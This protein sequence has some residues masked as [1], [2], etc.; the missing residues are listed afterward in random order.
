MKKTL[1]GLLIVL[2]AIGLAACKGGNEPP[3]DTGSTTGGDTPVAQKTIKNAPDAVGDIVLK[4]GR[5]IA[6]YDGLTLT[7]EEKASAIAV[8]FYAGGDNDLG[9]R[10]LGV[11]LFEY[12]GTRSCYATNQN[13]MGGKTN[14]ANDEINGL[15]NQNIIEADEDDYKTQY[16]SSSDFDSDHLDNLKYPAF[17][18]ADNYYDWE[19]VDIDYEYSNPAALCHDWYVPA[20]KELTALLNKHAIINKAFDKISN[21]ADKFGNKAYWSST[22][23]NVHYGTTTTEY[24][25]YNAWIQSLYNSTVNNPES[26][27]KYR[28]YAVRAIRAF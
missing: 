12:A 19:G 21:T 7:D 25:Y 27:E 6:Y 23:E 2:M 10:K 22:T 20:I 26:I 16:L 14:A 9:N 18:W 17:Y 13:I 15:N 11:G 1:S 8:I 24:D 3:A 4:D 28:S 5:A